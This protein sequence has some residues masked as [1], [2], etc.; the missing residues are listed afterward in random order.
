MKEAWPFSARYMTSPFPLWSSGLCFLHLL[1]FYVLG[2]KIGLHIPTFTSV[3]MN[4]LA[5]YIAQAL[6]IDMADDFAAEQW[7]LWAGVLGF[8]MFWAGFAGVAWY[9]HRRRI[10][11]KL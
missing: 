1:V 5:L 7:P 11:V 8:A 4:P 3:G 6:I 10:Y 9:L 2:D